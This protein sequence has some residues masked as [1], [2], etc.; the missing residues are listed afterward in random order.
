MYRIAL[1]NMPFAALTLPS[2][3]LTQLK[4]VMDDTFG[5]E[6]DTRV[7]Y[8]NHD[9]GRFIGPR[10]YHALASGMEHHSSGMGDWFFRQVAFPDLES[11]A[12]QY[13]RRFYRN[14]DDP[15][16]REAMEE[17]RA[18]LRLFMEHLV[19]EHRLDQAELVGFTSMFSQ[20]VASF[21]MARLLK[22]RN[23]DLTVVVGGANC[24][25]PMGQAMVRS[26]AAVDYTFSGP[27]LK[28][29]PAFVRSRLDGRPGDCETI[30]GVFS[31]TNHVAGSANPHAEGLV[32]LGAPRGVR[33]L[34][35]ELDINVP[36]PLDYGPFLDAIEARFAP[37]EVEP[38]LTFETSRGCW[39]GQRAHCTFCGLNGSTMSYRSM[40]PELA[41]DLFHSL[42]RHS[43]R[44]SRLSCVDN[45][46]PQN[47][48]QEVFPLLETPPG[49]SIFYEVKAD[50]S[51]SDLQVLS[52]AR[53]NLIQP[54]IES[55]ATST[56][57]L[58]R[59][60]TTAFT[61]VQLLVNCELYGVSPSWNLLV[62]F[63]GEGGEVYDGYLAAIPSLLHFM[64]PTGAYPVRFDRYS[65]YF[66]QAEEY[67]L[68]LVPLDWY[69]FTY[70]F[71]DEVM[72]DL[73]YYFANKNY[74]V[75]YLAPLAERLPRL[76]AAVA[77]WQERYSGKDGKLRPALFFAGGEDGSAVHDTRTGE[78]QVHR[79]D[80]AGRE[81]LARLAAPARIRT[82]AAELAHLG[83]PLLG[84]RL[85]ELEERRLVFREND[86]VMSVVLPRPPARWVA[87]AADPAEAIRSVPRRAAAVP[88]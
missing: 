67:G 56:L 9:F 29:F 12:E 14:P 28:S 20:N 68:R 75:S 2:I 86:R 8:L 33:P 31:R 87:P 60:G 77:A 44:C 6:V 32:A 53:V 50:L 26:I 84:A 79:L 36:V 80:A 61:N 85:A 22:A 51:E 4:R 18:G 7:V 58:M 10:R 19:D 74:G 48:L 76:Q 24:E 63:P 73:A 39:W 3:A 34:G 82:L 40:K 49:M 21:A 70:P 42:F 41:L 46:V 88:R 72:D 38:V 65:P 66:V 71:G 59:K 54:G 55:L 43:S 1:I 37:D 52:A 69:A 78:L 5:A 16:F 17:K 45:I 57:K 27:A 25:A 64:P 15:G 83:E 30:D 47:Y 62:G 23:P 81:I 11:N 13:Y 35:E